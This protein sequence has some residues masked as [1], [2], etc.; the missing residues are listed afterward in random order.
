MTTQANAPVPLLHGFMNCARHCWC[1]YDEGDAVV[2]GLG[3]GAVV[4][5]MKAIPHDH[6]PSPDAPNGCVGC[7]IEEGRVTVQ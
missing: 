5:G 1:A 2:Q 4:R 7:A 3:A 6:G